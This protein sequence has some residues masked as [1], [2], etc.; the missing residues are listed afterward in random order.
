M[1]DPYEFDEDDEPDDE[2]EEFECGAWFNGKFDYYHCQLAGT[3]D[4]DWEC[5]YSAS[6]RVLKT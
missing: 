3:E 2:D 5:P 6:I 1:S 4:C